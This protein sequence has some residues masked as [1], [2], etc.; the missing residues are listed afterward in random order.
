MKVGDSHLQKRTPDPNTY[1]N[2]NHNYCFI[3]CARTISTD[4]SLVYLL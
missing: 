1:Y 3:Y 4:F 2:E